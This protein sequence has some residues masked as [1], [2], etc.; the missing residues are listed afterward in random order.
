MAYYRFPQYLDQSDHAAFGALYEP[1]HATP[2]S[3][4]Y[5][6]ETCGHNAVSTEGHPL[7]PQNHHQH[8]SWEA[9][10]WRL[11]VAAH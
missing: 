10:R 1:G 5:R 8:P 9:I 6:C 4:I 3:G 2:F 11:I 7:P